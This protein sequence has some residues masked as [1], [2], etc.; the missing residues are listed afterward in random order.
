MSKSVFREPLPEDW[1]EALL[2]GK[3]PNTMGP[4]WDRLQKAQRELE[5]AVQEARTCLAQNPLTPMVA[6]IA[7]H[8]ANRQGGS[9]ISVDNNGTVTL[10]VDAEGVT[11]GGKRWTSTLPPLK[12]L[13]KTAERLGIDPIPYGRGKKALLTALEKV[14]REQKESRPKKRKMVKTAPSVSGPHIVKQEI[15]PAND[16]LLKRIAEKGCSIDAINDILRDP[17]G[18]KPSSR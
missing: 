14:R 5:R 4:V 10:V 13:R 8:Q 9:T 3:G 2:Q 11:E 12:E 18:D 1:A 15:R 7:A 6:Q 17:K 16:G